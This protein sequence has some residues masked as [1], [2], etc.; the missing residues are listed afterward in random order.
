MDERAL[1]VMRL[2]GWA[3][4]QGLWQVAGG[5]PLCTFAA[6]ELEELPDRQVAR[7]DAESVAVSV[8]TARRN[9]EEIGRLARWAIA[10]E[11]DVQSRDGQRFG[12]IRV[13]FGAYDTALAGEALYVFRRDPFAMVQGPIL[14]LQ[15]G[16]AG[17]ELRQA[18]LDGMHE[19]RAAEA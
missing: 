16:E 11:G 13:E 9:L 8:A 3:L 12:A 1:A 14:R 15:G 2:A 4:A 7:V 6:W 10:A 17:E 18:V 5:E 19:S